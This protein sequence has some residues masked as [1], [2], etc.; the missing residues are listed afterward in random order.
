MYVYIYTHTDSWSDQAQPAPRCHKP[1][2]VNLNPNFWQF[3]YEK[4]DEKNGML[5]PHSPNECQ[6]IH[7]HGFFSAVL[8]WNHRPNWFLKDRN[9]CI[10]MAVGGVWLLFG[11]LSLE[12]SGRKH[13]QIAADPNHSPG[14]CCFEGVECS[15]VASCWF[16]ASITTFVHPTDMPQFPQKTCAT[17]SLQHL[18]FS[19]KYSP[20]FVF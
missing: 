18:K 20:W 19:N 9:G 5:V 17:S 2:M 13:G 14:S 11:R 8:R 10:C 3:S 16:L 12:R 1:K 7:Q 6:H 15:H 4:C